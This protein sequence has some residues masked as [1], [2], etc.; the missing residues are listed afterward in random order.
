MPAA[1]MLA[2]AC[3]RRSSSRKAPTWTAKPSSLGVVLGGSGT[4]PEAEMGALGEGAAACADALGPGPLPLC[5]ARDDEA[6]AS[7]ARDDEAAASG[8]RDDEA[9]ACGAGSGGTLSFG[10]ITVEGS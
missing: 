2:F 1:S 4:S 7:G 10:G 9:A 8:A 5:G 3:L 6:A